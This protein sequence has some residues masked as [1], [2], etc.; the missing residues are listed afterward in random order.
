MRQAKTVSWLAANR[1]YRGKGCLIWPFARINGYGILG[2]TVGGKRITHYAH[3]WMCALVNGPPPSPNHEAAHECGNGVGG[4]VHPLHVAWKTKSQN[5][6]DRRRHGTKSMGWVGK[7][8][9]AQAAQI[10]ALKGKKLQR[11]IAA[12]FGVSRANVSLIHCGKAWHRHN[13]YR[14]IRRQSSA[15]SG[16]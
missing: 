7:L 16:T 13:R 1:H 10:R 12:M 9:E 5:Q 4:C 6:A 14:D 8:T 3:R 2:Q 11:E 15:Y